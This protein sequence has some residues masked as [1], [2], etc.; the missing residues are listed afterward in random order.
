MPLATLSLPVASN[1]ALGRD[2]D[3]DLDL[4]LVRKLGPFVAPPEAFHSGAGS[5]ERRLWAQSEWCLR[6]CLNTGS[7]L[8]FGTPGDNRPALPELELRLWCF[9]VWSIR[10]N[11]A[12]ERGQHWSRPRYN[13][14]QRKPPEHHLRH[15]QHKPADG[16]TSTHPPATATRNKQ[17][18]K[19]DKKYTNNTDDLHA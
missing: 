11:A 19:K 3:L 12:G 9:C 5:D 8:G 10:A 1:L 17:E 16:M 18:D 4:D 15:I 2:L 13:W 7:E 14:V 6:C